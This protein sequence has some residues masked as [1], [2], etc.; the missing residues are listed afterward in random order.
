MEIVSRQ[1]RHYELLILSDRK[2]TK[3]EEYRCIWR[4]LQSC[5]ADMERWANEKF[6]Q[7]DRKFS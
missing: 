1:P 3:F 5:V 6:D 4:G 2:F 7:M